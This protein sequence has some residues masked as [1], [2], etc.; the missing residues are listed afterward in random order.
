MD[1]QT[2]LKRSRRIGAEEMKVLHTRGCRESQAFAHRQENGHLWLHPKMFRKYLAVV[3]DKP[4]ISWV[5]LKR[6]CDS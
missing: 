3:L 4:P 6:K 2:A 1:N 5:F